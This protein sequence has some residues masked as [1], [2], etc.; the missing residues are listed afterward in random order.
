MLRVSWSLLLGENTCMGVYKRTFPIRVM[1]YKKFSADISISK[2]YSSVVAEHRLALPPGA[3]IV[4]KTITINRLKMFTGRM[5]NCCEH[6]VQQV[7]W[8]RVTL[9]GFYSEGH[10]FPFSVMWNPDRYLMMHSIHSIDCEIPTCSDEKCVR[11]Y[12][13]KHRLGKYK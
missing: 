11:E 2:L 9:G 13:R 1:D 6:H 4:S 7:A 8:K 3:T 12:Q 10:L 5:F